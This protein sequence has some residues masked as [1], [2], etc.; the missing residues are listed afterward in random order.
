MRQSAGEDRGARAGSRRNCEQMCGQGR[1]ACGPVLRKAEGGV[2]SGPHGDL[3]GRRRST[4]AHSL[5]VACLFSGAVLEGIIQSL[6]QR[7]PSL[8]FRRAET[9]A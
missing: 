5:E 7:V 3:M 6:R 1:G 2:R 4:F 8:K 9:P